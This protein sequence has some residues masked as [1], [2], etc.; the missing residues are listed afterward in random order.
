M[1]KMGQWVLCACLLVACS[2]LNLEEAAAVADIADESHAQEPAP[3]R[4]ELKPSEVDNVEQIPDVKSL[5]KFIYQE[6]QN[7]QKKEMSK[8]SNDEG[9]EIAIGDTLKSMEAE[10]AVE[11]E[12][13][14][15]V[16]IDCEVGEWSKFGACDKPC[17]GGVMKRTRTVQ[18]KPRNGGT[19]CPDLSNEVECNTES[20]ASE[21]YQRRATRRK[22]TAA[23]KARE[24]MIN[25]QKIAMA[26]KATDTHTMMKRTREVMRKMVHTEI[27]E[28]HLPGETGERSAEAQVRKSLQQA[29]SENAV[30]N[31]MKTYDATKTAHLESE[32]ED[33]EFK[34]ATQQPVGRR[35]E[36]PQ[37]TH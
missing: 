31:A 14:S 8:Y 24:A 3:A 28:V 5:K 17:D 22:L 25:K 27:A 35:S 11:E 32:E 19:Q 34:Q 37:P 12:L 21:A 9:E 13:Q 6:E 16:Q 10:H 36:E 30:R 2:A 23:E 18:R 20:C 26:M 4:D 33:H 29:M 15:E 7:V 1:V